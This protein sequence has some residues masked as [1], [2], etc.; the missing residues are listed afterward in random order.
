MAFLRTS[1]SRSVALRWFPYAL[2]WHRSPASQISFRTPTSATRTRSSH[3]PTFN[4]SPKNSS[5]HAASN[6]F[7][8]QSYNLLSSNVDFLCFFL[9]LLHSNLNFK[10]QWSS[11]SHRPC[12]IRGMPTPV[13]A[14]DSNLH[15]IVYYLVQS[16]PKFD[17]LTSPALLP[18]HMDKTNKTLF[19]TA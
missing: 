8:R 6:Y 16:V 10:C 3:R 11:R 19:F 7:L 18:A 12:S 13:A 15:F 14:W 2:S 17:Y 9:S 1:A 4:L 5:V